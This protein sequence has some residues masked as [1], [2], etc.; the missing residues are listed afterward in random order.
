MK[1]RILTLLLLLLAGLLPVQAVGT[2][3]TVNYDSLAHLP[4]DRLMQLGRQYFEQR[5]PASAL[6]CF[7]IVS[8]RYADG[9]P[10]DEARHSIRAMNNCACVYKFFYFDYMQAYEYFT[11]AIDLCERI[12]YDE[13]LPVIQV[14]LGDLLNDYGVNYDSETLEKQAQE[15]FDQC[16]DWSFKNKNWELMATAFFNLSNQ[17]YDLDLKRYE[18]LFSEQVPDTVLDLEYVRLQYKGIQHVQDGQYALARQC[19]EAQLDVIG[20]Q[21]EPVRDSL[22]TYMSIA[23][24][25][26]MEGDDTNSAR[27]LLMALQMAE[28]S[29]LADVA[30]DICK[31]LSDCYQRM[32]D[33][34]SRQQYRLLYL[35][36][37]EKHRAGRLASIGELNFIHEL[38]KEEQ[39]SQQEAQ[40]MA[41]RHRQQ[42]YALL[43]GLLLLLVVGVAALLLWRKNRQLKARN[44]S[45]FEKTQQVIKVEAEEQKLRRSTQSDEQRQS[46]QARIHEVLTNPQM[47]CQQDFTVARL[48]KLVESNTTYVSQAINDYYG[49]AF[50]TVLGSYRVKEACHRMND[51]EQYGNVTIEAIATSVG[52]KS[53]TSF[54]NAFK[55]ETGLT[56]SEYMRIAAQEKP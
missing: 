54:V 3:V 12:H 1:N 20:A 52:F 29:N 50:S 14:N 22:S 37:K 38:H 47:V 15:L 45:L 34:D 33:E 21:W 7:S 11:R 2:D 28:D 27:Y 31:L 56:P 51:A 36:K 19:F 40:M 5:V 4:S 30:A 42:Q 6:A 41:V 23:H 46:L 44:R 9:L 25:Y 39:R 43:A 17:R 49:A 13:F 16:V 24:T 26:K 55:R 8:E 10:D 48:A 32:G 18:V 35:E 53:R